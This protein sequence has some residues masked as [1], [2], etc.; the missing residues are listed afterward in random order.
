M[1]RNGG[2]NIL[3]HVPCPNRAAPDK[4]FL[5]NP[6]EYRKVSTY[7]KP[8]LK[9]STGVIRL[10]G[11]KENNNFFPYAASSLCGLVVYLAITV[12]SGR[13]EAW[14]DG[15]YYSIGI[16]VM[17]IAAFVI[18]YLFPAR[19]WRWA[20]GMAAGQAAGAMLH[21]S[22]LSLLPFAVIF[23]AVISIPQFLSAFLGAKYAARKAVE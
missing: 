19:P 2:K 18:G 9:I 16:P 22:S 6:S 23:M 14:D 5:I 11:I 8:E 13:N 21:G 12:A 15:S 17:C 20:L 4:F 10:N 1:L 7:Q 3:S